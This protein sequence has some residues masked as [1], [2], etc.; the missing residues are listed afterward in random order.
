MTTLVGV[1]A[2]PYILAARNV[3]DAKTALA[4]GPGGANPSANDMAGVDPE[5]AV[6]ELQ[7]D[8]QRA[9]AYANVRDFG[10]TGDGHTDDTSALNAAIASGKPLYFPA[11]R[12]LFTSLEGLDSEDIRWTGAGSAYTILQ[13]TAGGV[14][15]TIGTESGFRNGVRISGFTISGN[16]RTSII[17]RTIALSR[18][19]LSDINLCEGSRTTGIAWQMDGC[20]LNQFSMVMCSLNRQPMASPP[21]EGLRINA[22]TPLGNSSNNTFTNCYFEGG[23]RRK[24]KTI[25]IGVRLTGADQNLFLGGSA[26]AC[27]VYGLLVS[28]KCRYNSFLAVGFENLDA[29][30]ADVSDAGISTC[31]SN[32]YSS[33]KMVLQG[34]NCRVIGGYY[35]SIQLHASATGCRI[36]DVS[37]NAWN[38]GNGGLLDEGSMTFWSNIYDLDQARHVYPHDTRKRLRA[39]QSPLRWRN[40]TGSWASVII[41]SGKSLTVT[42]HRGSDNWQGSDRTP[43]THFIAPGDIIEIDYSGPAPD[44]SYAPMRGLA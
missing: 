9:I 30:S 21:R 28:P 40:D 5:Q 4:T 10:A 24:K 41:Q 27:S 17:L 1:G 43:E 11:G 22:L 14:A 18:S 23:G 32:C 16:S 38:T 36:E 44:V 33:H 13:C 20:S 31:Y 39:R 37:I 26:E 7:A 2:A 29:M 34:R 3:A 15:L 19:C 35:E 42:Y 25:A 12:Y 6:A 8:A